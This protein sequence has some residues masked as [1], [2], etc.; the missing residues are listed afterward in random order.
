[1]V[2][3]PVLGG[4]PGRC[5][6]WGRGWGSWYCSSLIDLM[7]AKGENLVWFISLKDKMIQLMVRPPV[8]GGQPCM[9][10]EW[11]RGV[12]LTY[13]SSLIDLIRAKGENLVG[14]LSLMLDKL[15]QLM[16]R[17]P[18]LGGQPGRCRGRG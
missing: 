7:R 18:V 12:G 2:R 11:R 8:L 16:V 5:R 9:Y 14:F 10:R 3:P 4:Q 13:C 6:G 15:I 17:L 1:M